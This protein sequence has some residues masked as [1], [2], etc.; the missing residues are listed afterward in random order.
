ML[1]DN[2]ELHFYHTNNF[3]DLP[4]MMKGGI[5]TFGSTRSQN[6]VWRHGSVSA[7]GLR[8]VIVS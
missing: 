7:S 4:S 1:R 5:P 2:L 6:I 8:N 3:T